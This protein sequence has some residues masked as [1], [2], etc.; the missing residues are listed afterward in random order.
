M[1]VLKLSSYRCAALL[2]LMILSGC[3]SE[4]CYDCDKRDDWALPAA[5]FEQN[6]PQRDWI[7]EHEISEGMRNGSSTPSASSANKSRPPDDR[8]CWNL[9][10]KGV[11]YYDCS[12][13]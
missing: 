3:A 5:R 6:A 13:R 10:A 9:S 11:W 8:P 12:Q 1:A 7:R 4:R 2:A